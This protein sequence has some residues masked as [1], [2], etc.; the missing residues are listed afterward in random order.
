MTLRVA[1][2]IN[3]PWAWM[4]GVNYLLNMCRVLRAHAPDIEPVVFAPPDL[5]DPI[6]Q[7]I[8]ASNGVPP[9]PMAPQ[10]RRTDFLAVLGVHD[11]EAARHFARHRIDLVFESEGYYGPRPPFPVLAWLP[12]FQHRR[13]PHLFTRRN[14][15]TREARFRRMLSTRGDLLLSSQ[16]S[17]NDLRRFF[18]RVPVN[19]H[20]VPFV[21]R[22]ERE[23]SWEEADA[24]R[25]R[26]GLPEQFMFLPGQFWTHK[27]QGIVVEALAKLGAA[28][29]VVAVTG[30]RDPRAPQGF[31]RLRAR[32]DAL[33]IGDRFRILDDQR[34]F[35]LLGLIARADRLINPSLFEGWSTT[36][37]E[38]KTLGTE[39]LLSDLPVHRE[40]AGESAIYFDPLDVDDC[41][42]AIRAAAAG[43]PRMRRDYGMADAADVAQRGF[44]D[45]LRQAFLS[46][47]RQ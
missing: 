33:G 2:R 27:N 26:N 39:L 11:R 7:L 5:D 37:E 35:D 8:I 15:L 17:L 4:G 30:R 16:D 14:W 45:R 34:Y 40:Q 24:V 31:D 19:V 23:I 18:R 42:R 36:V 12:D 20:V 44:A 10:S 6:R 43:G 29:P 21:V 9:I 22:L 41:V 1:L 3:E 47:A 38:A 46:A 13:L 25:I 32:I 28:A